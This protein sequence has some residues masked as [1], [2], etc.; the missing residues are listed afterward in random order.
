M[1]KRLISYIL[2]WVLLIEGAA[3]QLSTIV[4][5]IYHEWRDLK[6]FIYVGAALLLL[7]FLLVFKKPSSNVMYLKDG[8]A[9]TALSWI[10]LSVAGCLPLW[11]SGTIPHFVDAVFETISGF[12]TT[13]ATILKEIEHLP[14]CM[15][16]WR[17]FSHFL[18]GMGVVVF[19]LAI[20][21]RLGGS[22]SINLMKAESTG[23][24]VSKSMPKL[25]N[26]AALLYGIYGGL[27]ALECILLLCGG[28]NLFDAVTT[29]FSTAGTGGFMVYNDSMARFS[30]YLQTVVAVFMMLFGVNFYIYIAI[31]Y[32][33][34]KQ[35]LK[36]EELWMYIGITLG[37]TAVIAADLY[38]HRLYN[39][40]LYQAIH[41]SFFYITSVGSST[42]MALSDVNKWP[43]LSKALVLIVTCI[44]ACAGST[45]GGFKVSRFMILLKGVRKEFSLILHPRKVHTVKMDKKKITHEVTRSVSVY[46]VIYMAIIITTT[47]LISLN[48]FDFTTNLTSVLATLNNTGPGMNIVGSTGNYADFSVF[49]K[50]VFCFNMLAGRLELYPFLLIFIPSAWRKN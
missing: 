47:I 2:G 8:F 27:T 36:N 24:S 35:A 10:L 3:M 42:G 23:P 6:S 22:Q 14:R 40:D 1:N 48:G 49:S 11:I 5:I 28:M 17:S 41:Q 50:L 18:G 32:R 7:G 30:P 38:L 45:G 29:S 46:F 25:R 9:A 16:F 34:F 44:G 12:T 4:G 19:L 33:R 20:I 13:G 43:E 39:G 15:L 31:L 21:P 26:Y 37:V